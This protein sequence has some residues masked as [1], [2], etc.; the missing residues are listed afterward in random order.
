MK[1]VSLLSKHVSRLVKAFKG[2]DDALTSYSNQPQG[3]F[4]RVAVIR[5]GNVTLKSE[6]LDIE[7]VVPFDDDAEANEAEMIV[8]NLSK[9]TIQGLKYNSVI[10]IEAGY[11]G[12]TGLIF[13]GYIS[14]VTTKTQ[15]L[16]KITTIKAISDTDLQERDIT[17]I[18]YKAGTK[19]SYILKDLVSKIKLPVAVF[20]VRR[21]YTYKD[22][23]KVDGGLMDNIRKYAEVC[24]V[25]VYI[26]N[27]KI[28]VR[29]ISEG[30][31]ISF[32]IKPETGLIS[33]E[34]FE[35]EVTGEDYKDTVKGWEIECLLQHRLTTAAIV[36]LQ[37]QN[38]N[39]RFRV[40]SG[41][42]RFNPSEAITKAKMY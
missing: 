27:G 31:N 12:D 22:K 32:V 28:Y 10:T 24:G 6:E 7:F 1:A 39:G 40:C 15:G 25:S 5:S 14:K 42:H 4:G 3:M 23:T 35:E 41:E 13:S 17:E 37:S 8:Y 20:K 36:T 21:D 2:F 19:A 18:S 33:V 16:D 29:H 34:D 9:S 30:E 38:A 26:N 11:K